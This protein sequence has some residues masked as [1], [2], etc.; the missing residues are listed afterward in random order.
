[1][2]KI[3]TFEQSTQNYASVDLDDFLSVGFDL[4]LIYGGKLLREKNYPGDTE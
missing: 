1:M 3:G 2:A 4:K